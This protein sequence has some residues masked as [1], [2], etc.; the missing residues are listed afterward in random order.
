MKIL[1]TTL[2]SQYIHSNLA[3]K[4]LY[5]VSINKADNL[6]LREFTVNNQDD[7]IYGELLR[8]SYDIVCFSCYIWN[9]EKTLY[10]VETLKK[11][12]PETLVLLGGPEVT[13][14]GPEVM[15]KNK[16]VDF[17]LAGEGEENFP[18]LLSALKEQGDFPG[19]EGIKGLLYRRDGK[20]YVNPS[21]DPVDFT[22]V[23]FPFLSLVGEAD[24]L[25]Y[26]ESSR[27]CPFTCSYCLSAIERGVRPLPVNRVKEDLSYFIYKGVRQVKFVDRTFNYNDERCMEILRYLMEADN[28]VTNFHF[29]ICGDLISPRLLNLL[30]DARPGLFQFEIG[31]QTT[32][33][34]ALAAIN[35]SCD[36]KTLSENVRRI[37]NMG[38]IHMHLDL[39][40]GLPFEDYDSFANSFNQVYS[41]KPH[42]LQ[43]GFLKL[44]PGTPLR[45]KAEEYG[46]EYRSKAPYEVITNKFLSARDLTKMK[47]VEHIVDLY[48][49]RGGFQESLQYLMHDRSPFSAYEDLASFYYKKGFQHRSHKK[50]DLYRI[51]NLY[52]VWK[53]IVEPGKA[54]ELLRLLEKDMAGTMNPEAVKKFKKTGWELP[55]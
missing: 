48:Y 33:E 12:R 11:A 50:E 27:G 22:R 16:G 5:A 28:G 20:I 44:L 26:Y 37:M 30:E 15:K 14:R 21:P 52:G 36:F 23:P 29:E 34:A 54:E 32:N 31:V 43:L 40:A 17:I 55:E 46:Y 51:L 4:Y 25:M 42:M 45:E 9:I 47:M 38:N 1:L 39:I 53:D 13:W 19:F 24:K 10:L 2:N 8:G 41:L 49:N 7:Y 6:E 3:L 18:R 35:R